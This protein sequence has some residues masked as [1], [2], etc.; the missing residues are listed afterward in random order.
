MLK[1]T[2]KFLLASLCAAA[3]SVS[4]A[5]FGMSTAQAAEVDGPKVKWLVSLFGNRR[6]LTEG[7]EELAATLSAKTDGNFELSLQYGAVLSEP[8]ENID[9][10]QIGG[11]EA[12]MFCPIYH[13]SKTPALGGLDLALLPYKNLGGQRDVY[14]AYYTHP[15]VQKEFAR[16]NAVPL[17]GGLLPSYE[18]MGKGDAPTTPEAWNGLRLNASGGMAALMK[19]IGANPVTIASPDAYTT[20]D[21][22]VVDGVVFP[23]TYAFVA[24]RLHETADWVTDGWGLGSISC[25]FA[26]NK[27]AYESLPAQYQKLIQDAKAGAYEHQINSYA[28]IDVANEKLF[29]DQK[30]IRIEKSAEIAEV[31]KAAAAPSW[32][33]WVES[34]TE[35]G[36]PGQELFDFILAET[37]KIK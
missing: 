26:A 32:N 37:A 4:A 29:N 10:I 18:I 19:S 13:P 36:L 30:L 7:I 20:L 17:I 25:H 9:G 31:I 16:W 23:Y 5:S 33:A 1:T 3:V 6:G 24:Y 11:F 34:A 21:R 2:K 15:V 8:K 27:D 22:G 28:E 14:E 12:A 35:A